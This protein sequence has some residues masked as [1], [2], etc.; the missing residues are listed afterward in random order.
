MLPV[1]QPIHFCAASD[2]VRLAYA[3]S[4][5]GPPIVK[6]AKWL[7]HLELDRRAPCGVTGSTT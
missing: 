7:T 4:G 2:G 1:E 3:V 5:Q 6:V